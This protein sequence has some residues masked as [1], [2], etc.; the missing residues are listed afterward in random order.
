MPQ[1]MERALRTGDSGESRSTDL[2]VLDRS[3][4]TYTWFLK[5]QLERSLNNGGDLASA[6]DLIFLDGAKEWSVDGLAVVL[7]GKAPRSGW[8]ACNG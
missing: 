3:F 7:A 4:S 1:G 6:Y 5:V 8:M 2:V